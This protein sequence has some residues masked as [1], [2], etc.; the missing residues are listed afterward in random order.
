M[1][2]IIASL[3]ISLLWQ[4]SFSQNMFTKFIENKSVQWAVNM[5]D[6]FHFA[7][8][9][10]SLILRNKFNAAQIKVSS[11]EDDK[12]IS[13]I[14]YASKDAVISRIAPDNKITRIDAQGNV[15]EIM[16]Y[17]DNP[18][19]SSYYFDAQTNDLVEIQQILYLQSG[20]LKSYIPWVSPKYS[21]YTSW[22][23]KL[24]VANV[25]NTAFNK[26]RK[27][28]AS[29]KKKVQLL[30]STK[31]MMR[32]DTSKNM[33]K[34]L[35]AQNLLQ[36]LWPHLH[37]KQ[38]EIYRADSAI[39]IPFEKINKTL[40]D[41]QQINIPQY[42][43]EGNITAYKILTQQD[44]PLEL[45]SITGVEIIQHWF[46]K[47]K[48]NIVFNTIEQLVLYAHKWNNGQL[49]GLASP[50]LKIMLQ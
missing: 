19:F 33:L 2:K 9:N 28:A 29:L 40:V 25:F 12:N 44:Q 37:K 45:S 27:T 15:S 13:K 32:L 21:V 3:I 42:D 23:E 24:G 34:Q 35:Y 22:G 43:A 7:N 26:Q 16:A 6:T 11:I 1:I 49:D 8:P 5:N 14:N 36:A 46:Y 20:R 38:Y 48:K 41:T 31:T 50:I 39:K 18:L 17:A 4:T 30:G 10:L 47:A